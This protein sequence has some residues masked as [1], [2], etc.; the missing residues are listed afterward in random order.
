MSWDGDEYQKRFDDLEKENT[1][2]KK[3]AGEAVEKVEE[4]AKRVQTI[5]D[6]PL[7]RAPTGG[8]APKEGDGTFLGKKAETRE[9]K[10]AILHDLVKTEGPDAI[11]LALIKASQQAGGHKL[12]LAPR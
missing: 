4:L 3:V 8:F 9:D 1:E 6:T 5:E 11:A 2:L 7:P 12:S 10:I